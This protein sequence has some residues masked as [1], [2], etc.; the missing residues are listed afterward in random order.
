M[1]TVHHDLVCTIIDDSNHP[2][3]FDAALEPL[4]THVKNMLILHARPLSR[5]CTYLRTCCRCPISLDCLTHQLFEMYSHVKRQSPQSKPQSR[6]SIRFA[7][8]M[9]VFHRLCPLPRYTWATAPLSHT[10][11]DALTHAHAHNP[12]SPFDRSPSPSLFRPP[13]KKGSRSVK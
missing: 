8:P 3:L 13:T 1:C 2:S 11:T 4:R 7:M 10:H 12:H 5:A 9:G 6:V